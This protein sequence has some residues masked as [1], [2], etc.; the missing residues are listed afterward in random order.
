MGFSV[1]RVPEVWKSVVAL[2]FSSAG[3][4]AAIQAVVEST[5]AAPESW[6]YTLS[7]AVGAVTGFAT[8]LKRNKP[9][10]DLVL[11][12]ITSY[13]EAVLERLLEDP[14]TTSKVTTEELVDE[15]IARYQ[16]KHRLH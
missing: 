11:E 1:K 6:V 12:L 16:A 4:L 9:A 10:A 14:K 8:W 3:T 2:V 13:D 7:L 5:G 15:I